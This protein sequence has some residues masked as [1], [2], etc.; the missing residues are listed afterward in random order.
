[1]DNNVEE[2]IFDAEWEV[3]TIKRRIRG[4]MTIFEEYDAKIKS[5]SSRISRNK[6]LIRKELGEFQEGEEETKYNPPLILPFTLPPKELIHPPP[7]EKMTLEE[8]R[9]WYADNQTQKEP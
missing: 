8:W 5:L 7:D 9:E 6:A 3:M 2:E 1:M 4:I